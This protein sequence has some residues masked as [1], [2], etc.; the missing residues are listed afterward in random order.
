MISKFAN[1]K[2]AVFIDAANI[3]YS[4]QSLGWK[5][6]YKKLIKYFKKETNLGFVGFYYGLIKENQGQTNFFRMLVDQGYVLRTKPVKYI[7]TKKG[8]IL[9]GNLD[10]EIAFDILTKRENF[11]TCVLMS[12]DSDFEI[13]VRFLR[14]AGKRVIVMSTKNHVSLELIKNC[15]K[16]INLAK[17]KEELIRE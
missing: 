9:K 15:D 13:I 8:T 4:Q 17:L 5:V 2:T 14:E 10:I 11:D 12:G 6:D 3:L 1:G 16:Y 7:K